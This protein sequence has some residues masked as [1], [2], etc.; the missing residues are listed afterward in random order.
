LCV[1]LEINQGY[2]SFGHNF[3]FDSSTYVYKQWSQVVYWLLLY[4]KEF[5]FIF[6]Y[7]GM[8]TVSSAIPHASLTLI[9]YRLIIKYVSGVCTTRIFAYTFW[10]LCDFSDRSEDMSLDGGLISFSDMTLILWFDFL[11]REFP[12]GGNNRTVA[13][14]H[15]VSSVSG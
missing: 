6:W 5:L 15:G 11:Y 4:E 9:C 12:Q 1:K 7:E 2:F 3:T 8:Y 13:Q 14:L 10:P